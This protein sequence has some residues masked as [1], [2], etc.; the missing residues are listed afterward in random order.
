[1]AIRHDLEPLARLWEQIA[2]QRTSA[3]RAD[4]TSTL[5]PAS[6]DVA[7]S[8]RNETLRT[9]RNVFRGVGMGSYAAAEDNGGANPAHQAQNAR[10]RLNR[11]DHDPVSTLAYLVEHAPTPPVPLAAGQYSTHQANTPTQELWLETQR[12]A[13]RAAAEWEHAPRMTPVE[14]WSAVADAAALASTVSRV[15]DSLLVAA[16]HP[17]VRQEVRDT[18]DAARYTG[19]SLAAHETHVLASSGELPR[20]MDV[21]LG[22]PN[23]PIRIDSPEVLLEAQR[24]LAEILR[25]EEQSP[26]DIARIAVKHHAVLDRLNNVAPEPAPWVAH[27]QASLKQINPLSDELSS[28]T[29]TSRA[30]SHQQ[31]EIVRYLREAP[32]DSL[33]DEHLAAAAATITALH[34]S[35][36]EHLRGPHWCISHGNLIDADPTLLYQPTRE[37]ADPPRLLNR[38]AEAHNHAHTYA[39]TPEALA[40]TQRTP[41]WVVLEEVRSPVRTRPS[42]PGQPPKN[43][44]PTARQEH[45][46]SPSFPKRPRAKGPTAPPVAARPK[47]AESGLR[48]PER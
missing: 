41:A 36:Q 42:R 5:N 29:H 26:E 23:R 22:A 14:Q 21:T 13:V 19:M 4:A 2:K 10:Q 17:H 8:A 6:L 25:T 37:Q 40:P 44:V 45:A 32:S 11:V 33:S 9:C 34:E 18:L 35:T 1:M 27:A 3:D 31:D 39:R 7:L 47:R 48:S 12:A 43:V 38:L 15:D 46:H 30:A 28:I 16:S 20:V 24:R